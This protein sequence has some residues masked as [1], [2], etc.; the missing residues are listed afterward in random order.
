MTQTTI[1]FTHYFLR[2]LN[3]T[4]SGANG[5]QVAVITAYITEST[6]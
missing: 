4:A 5:R 3:M 2:S 1:G 6:Q